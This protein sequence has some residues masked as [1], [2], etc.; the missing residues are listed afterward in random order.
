MKKLR[1]K[2]EYIPQA[3]VVKSHVLLHHCHRSVSY[4]EMLRGGGGGALQT[5]MST[6]S[7]LSPLNI[8]TF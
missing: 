1:E 3:Q 4:Y 6:A 8:L 2:R 5:C 7:N